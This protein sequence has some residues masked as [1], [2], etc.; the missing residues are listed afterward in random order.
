MKKNPTGGL[1]GKTIH[2]L[3]Y[4]TGLRIPMLAGSA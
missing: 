3:D 2:F 4:I 1:I